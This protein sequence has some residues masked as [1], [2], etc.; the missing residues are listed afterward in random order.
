M[1]RLTILCHGATAASRRALFP[2]AGEPLEAAALAQAAA[3]GPQ[4]ARGTDRA[5]TSPLPRARQTAQALCFDARDDM[6]L[7]DLDFGRWT[8]RAMA[9]VGAAEPDALAAW[10][11]DAAAAPHGGETRADL[12]RRVGA[13]LRRQEAGRGHVVAVT[14]A[15]VIRAAVLHV[16]DA[17]PDAFWRI[18]VTPLSLT[19][20]RFDGR[21]WALRALGTRLSPAAPDS[22]RD[23]S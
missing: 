23:P 21:R 4:L 20:L 12:S 15:A 6:D 9:E 17:P 16:L 5:F 2:P 18:D 13:W 3:L 7:T 10:I 11:A 14:H 22:R 8:G 1:L 19:D